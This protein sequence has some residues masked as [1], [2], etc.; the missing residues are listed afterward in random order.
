MVLQ[1]ADNSSDLTLC[2]AIIFTVA[3]IRTFW[4]QLSFETRR[5]H[6]FTMFQHS[7]QWLNIDNGRREF[8][9][10]IKL[11]NNIYTWQIIAT[12]PHHESHWP[13]YVKGWNKIKENAPIKDVQFFHITQTQQTSPNTENVESVTKSK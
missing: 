1:T 5:W 4:L 7:L 3:T 6:I 10:N 8:Y 13:K 12:N 2:R 9:S 11:R